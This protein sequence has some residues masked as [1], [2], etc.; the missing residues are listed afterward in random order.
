MIGYRSH[1][2]ED[3]TRTLM[4]E[5][6]PEADCVFID[7]TKDNIPLTTLW[8]RIVKNAAEQ[9]V[10]LLNV[11][12]WVSPGWIIPLLKAFENPSV[13]VVGPGANQGTNRIDIGTNEIP[14]SPC[15]GWLERAAITAIERYKGQILDKDVLGFCFGLRRRTW[16]EIGGFD[17]SIPFYGNET[18]YNRRV[19]AHGK[20]VVKCFDSYVYHRG[21]FSFDQV[22]KEEK[23]KLAPPK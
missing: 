23:K 7:N 8:N 18:D 6:T 20:R 9:L 21:K 3:E 17:E 2:I 14:A 19:V 5:M 1:E 13:S 4:F 15:R 22:D 12:V 10:F 16:H 11:D